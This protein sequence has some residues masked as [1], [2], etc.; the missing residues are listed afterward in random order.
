VQR[1]VAFAINIK[2][3]TVRF[4][5]RISHTVV[6]NVNTRPSLAYIYT[7]LRVNRY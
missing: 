7:A 1:V 3:L 2:L 6:K 4:D 5:G